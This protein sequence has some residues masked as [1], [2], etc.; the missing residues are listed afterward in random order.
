MLRHGAIV[1]ANAERST[2]NAE[3]RNSLAIF[4]LVLSFSPR[5]NR[6]CSVDREEKYEEDYGFPLRS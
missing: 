2:S 5:A 1:K 6:I 4:I 3:L